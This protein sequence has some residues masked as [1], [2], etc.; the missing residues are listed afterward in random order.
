M[1]MK[2]PTLL[3]FRF[4]FNLLPRI[5]AGLLCGSPA[6]AEDVRA[7]EGPVKIF[8]LAGQSNMLGQGVNAELPEE[9]AAP[10]EG[11]KIWNRRGRAWEPV[12]PGTG[13]RPE[14]FGPE[15]TFARAIARA[16]PEE[17]IRLIKF[18]AGG[19]SL[20][21]DWAPPEGAPYRIFMRTA[22]QALED[23]EQNGIDYEIVGLLWL[24][25]ETDADHNKGDLYEENL[26]RFIAHMREA[27]GVPE[28]PVVIARIM[29]VAWGV[30]SGH[31]ALVQQAQENLAE[32]DPKVA[33]FST[34]DCPPVHPQKNRGH[35]GTK[36]QMIIG[37]RFAEA[38]RGMTNERDENEKM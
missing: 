34:D 31:A 18:A 22:R 17:D 19:S 21:Q 23:L 30:E 16:M 14:N 38:Y 4:H 9:L 27:F 2:H 1:F 12:A 37:K 5:L 11:V 35:Y 20:Y 24:Q 25:G 8:L 13:K 28:L 29:A 15:V 10:F 36:G 26:T 7:K 6:V 33:C 3:T 32:K